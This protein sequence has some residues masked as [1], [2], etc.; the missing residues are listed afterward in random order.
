[1]KKVVS[2][3]HYKEN[4]QDIVLKIYDDDTFE[5][6]IDNVLW[7]PSLQSPESDDILQ[8]DGPDSESEVP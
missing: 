3:L 7:D 1:M 4:K 5:K 8:E 6:Y 2:T